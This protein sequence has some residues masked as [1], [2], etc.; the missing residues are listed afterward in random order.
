MYKKTLTLML[1][2]III[3]SGSVAAKIC[4][5]V[6]IKDAKIIQ[7]NSAMNMGTRIQ[8]PTQLI[9]KPVVSN[10]DLWDAEGLANHIV[11]KP[12]SPSAQGEK[13]MLFAFLEDGTTIDIELT[14]VDKN[15]NQPC[16]LLKL[17][18]A[19]Q[20]VQDGLK[21]SYSRNTQQTTNESAH[22]L[23][24]QRQMI[25]MQQ[26][27]TEEKKKAVTEALRTYRYYI[28]TRYTW[29]QSGNNFVG[30]NL[31][32]DVYDDGRFTYIRLSQKN[33]GLLAIEAEVGGDIAVIPYKYDDSYGIYQ[34]SG[35]Y[36][37]FKMKIDN[38]SVSINRSDIKTNG[39]S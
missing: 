19:A 36:P 24:L 12:N 4:P 35:I 26:S 25:S 34:I 16:L 15:K 20:S 18:N 2:A 30:G 27:F 33:K 1:V 8:L 7:V 21:N 31:I 5:S 13:A 23:M 32:S 39:A 38:V 3:T 29:D 22:N 17:D 6:T 37:K 28:Y 14:R 11:V 10:P 9:G